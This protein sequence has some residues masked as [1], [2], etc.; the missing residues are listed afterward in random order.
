MQ[1]P[2]AGLINGTVLVTIPAEHFDEYSSM[3]SLETAGEIH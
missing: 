2:E 3:S 1:D